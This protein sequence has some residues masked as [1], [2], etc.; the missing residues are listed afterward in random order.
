MLYCLVKNNKVKKGPQSLPENYENISGFN[1]DPTLAF[2]HGWLPTIIEQPTLPTPGH[3]KGGII[4]TI[5]EST[6]HMTWKV[7]RYV[8]PRRITVPPSPEEVRIARLETDLAILDE[9][10]NL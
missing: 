2:S 1:L 5:Q 8:R 10:C 7:V 4:L 6:V 9:K 3:V